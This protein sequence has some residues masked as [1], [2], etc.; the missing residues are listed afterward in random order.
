M[1]LVLA[2]DEL[3][4]AGIRAAKFGLGRHDVDWYPLALFGFHP[5]DINLAG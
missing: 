3:R 4:L 1:W 2:V 5:D